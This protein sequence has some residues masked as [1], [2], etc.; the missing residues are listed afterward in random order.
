MGRGKAKRIDRIREYYFSLK[1]REIEELK[2]GG[3]PIINLGIGNPDLP[4][5]EETI[6]ELHNSSRNPAN[7]GYQS[8]QGILP[9]RIAYARWYRR[10]FNVDLDPV[11]E[12]LPLMGSK[13][14]IFNISMAF[15]DPG[16]KVLLPDPGYPTYRSVTEMVGAEPVVY[17]LSEENEWY[18]DPDR[19]AK[20]DLSGVK[21]MWVNYPH[22]PTGR[23]AS[24]R[25]FAELVHFGKT[26][27][28]L[29]CNDNPYSFILN[30]NPLS[31]LEPDGAKETALELNSLSKSH[32]MA[33]WRV[34][35][36]AGKK[37]FIDQIT[38][39]T[40]NI[41][42]GMFLP[43]QHAAIKALESPDGWYTNLRRKYLLRRKVVWEILD[44]LG[45]KYR[46][47]QGGLFIWAR[48]P[49]GRNSY[50][51]TD[52]ILKKVKLF[53]TPGAVFGEGGMNYI[54]ISLCN[55]ED[56]LNESK[57]RILQLM[58]SK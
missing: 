29:I 45:C 2:K 31:L 20:Q 3:D 42:S 9:L 14:G 13:E 37:E 15:L 17:P 48:I 4:P 22:M 56:I 12:V 8:Y 46:K 58:Q 55:R 36:V 27:D 7:H 19:L 39:I 34:G 52:E 26:Y 18:P 24:K 33:G 49:S 51:F 47:D 32:N 50:E 40:S 5:P 54:R 6:D 57:Q 10:F 11:H 23:K 38:K 21:L 16:D 35:M 43:L 53:I 44:L 28:I 25:L 41:H 1:L 30:D